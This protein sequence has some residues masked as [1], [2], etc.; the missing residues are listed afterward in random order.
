MQANESIFQAQIS[1]QSQQKHTHPSPNFVA[2]V[3]TAQLE[4]PQCNAAVQP[5]VSSMQRQQ[6]LSEFQN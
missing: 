4:W 5:A 1:K 3:A 2:H 6:G